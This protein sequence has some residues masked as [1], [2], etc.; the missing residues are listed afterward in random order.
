[1]N[2][3]YFENLLSSEEL[4]V[5]VIKDFAELEWNH[6][7]L[8]TRYFT[9]Q[10]RY[11][12]FFDIIVGN[13]NFNQKIE[14]F[15]KMSLPKKWVSRDN[16]VRSLKKLRKLR[17]LLAHSFELTDEDIHVIASD[18]ELARILINYPKSYN[19]EIINIKIRLRKIVM[20]YIR[21]YWKQNRLTSGSS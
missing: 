4:T 9:A 10:E 15:S 12:E 5:R 14:I 13:M 16:A 8:I 7:L 3:A 20:S 17:N 18:N 21:K 1:M 11:D 19:R 2:I 6:D